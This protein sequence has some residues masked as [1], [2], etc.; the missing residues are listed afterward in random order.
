MGVR[1]PQVFQLNA[2]TK[3]ESYMRGATNAA[4]FVCV[5]VKTIIDQWVT[6]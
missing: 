1:S 2:E 4:V 5:K 3:L 6:K